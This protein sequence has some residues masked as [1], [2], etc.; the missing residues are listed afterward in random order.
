[1]PRDTRFLPHPSRGGS[2]GYDIPFRQMVLDAYWAGTPPPEGMLSSVKRWNRNG[3]VPLRMT[4]NKPS[5]ALS[6][7]SNALAPLPHD[8]RRRHNVGNKYHRRRPLLSQPQA[9][10]RTHRRRRPVTVLPSRCC[11]MDHV[12]QREGNAAKWRQNNGVARVDGA[13]RDIQ[14][15][16]HPRIGGSRG[17]DIPLSQMMVDSYQAGGLPPREGRARRWGGK[18]RRLG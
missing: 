4:G 17:Y 16:S 2:R 13:S 1:M 10:V 3:I 9:V 11:R 7:Q 12:F 6:G 5:S 14:F 18:R 8:R 15:L